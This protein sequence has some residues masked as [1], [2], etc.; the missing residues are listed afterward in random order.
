MG[1]MDGIP[2]PKGDSTMIFYFAGAGNYRWVTQTL[3]EQLRDLAK[4]IL[5]EAGP[6]LSVETWIGLAFPI[7][8]WGAGAHAGVS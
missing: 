1:E 5:E 6:N 3:A 8:A 4:S 7:Y 2:G